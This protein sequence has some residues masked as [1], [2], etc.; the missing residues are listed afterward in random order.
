MYHHNNHYTQQKPTSGR[1]PVPRP[2]TSLDDE[3]Q[4]QA[5]VKFSNGSMPNVIV[6]GNKY[7]VWELDLEHI[8]SLRT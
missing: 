1:T 8:Y 5:D 2:R 7:I 3:E 4:R 6:G